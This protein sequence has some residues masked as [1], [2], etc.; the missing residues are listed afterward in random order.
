M[1]GFGLVDLLLVV[2]LV[3][4]FR[5]VLSLIYGFVGLSWTGFVWFVGLFYVVFVLYCD[6][7]V[8]GLHLGRLVVLGFWW[9]ACCACFLLV[10]HKM[11]VGGLW[12]WVGASGFGFGCV[13]VMI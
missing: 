6:L 3:W 4:G 2:S 1:F 13:L 10:W 7:V 5:I 11:V 9:L 12:F 8:G